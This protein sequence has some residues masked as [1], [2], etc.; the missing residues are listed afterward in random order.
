MHIIRHRF[1]KCFLTL[2]LALF[3]CNPVNP[4]SAPAREAGPP[5]ADTQKP[6][7]ALV[8]A[9]SS[10]STTEPAQ[11]RT[12]SGF[13][14]GQATEHK[15]GVQIIANK[16]AALASRFYGTISKIYVKEGEN[17][18]AGQPLISFDCREL[19]A[20]HAVAQAELRLHSSTDQA[21]SE[22]YAEKVIGSLE[23]NLSQAKVA[24][25]NARIKAINAKMANCKITAPFDGQV[26]D[27]KART[28]ETLLPGSPIMLIQASRDLGALVQ[29]P[30]A[31][32]S[33]L[34]PGTIFQAQIEETGTS[35]QAEVSSV[36]ARVDPASR[37]VKVYATISGIHS[38][39]LPGMGGH[40]EFDQQ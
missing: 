25:A 5:A 21:N 8:E 36:G 12:Q 28:Y 27:L 38:E 6:R 20:E 18:K 35:Y 24:E 7:N 11:P 2:A 1:Q 13:N 9:F 19:A 26:V 29:I 3:F 39:L 31:W 17:F 37:M 30:P 10:T 34:K 14:Q 23:K 40:A 16:E 33:W 4:M 15:T 22:L 32:L